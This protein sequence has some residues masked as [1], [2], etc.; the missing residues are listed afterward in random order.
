MKSARLKN[1]VAPLL[2]AGVFF[3]SGSVAQA[4]GNKAII[5]YGWDFLEAT[6]ED[7]FRNRAKFADCGADGVL[8]S[9]DGEKAN[10][11]KYQ[12]RRVMSDFR[13]G[14]ADF[15]RSLPQ[16][17]EITVC[18]GLR[19]SMALMLMTPAKRIRWDDDA[20]WA[21]IS[22]N[23]AMIARMAKQGGMKGVA[24][25]HEDYFKAR[26][27][28]ETPDD[29]DGVWAKARQ[30]GREVFGGL[31]AEFPDAKVLGFWMFSDG[32]RLWRAFLNGMLD[33]IPPE[34]RFID[35][36]ENYG[37]QAMADEGDFRADTWYILRSLRNAAVPENRAKYDRGVSVSFGQ[38]IDAYTSSN[39]ASTYFIGPM[40]GSRVE[41]LEDNLAAA[42]R[43]CD[44]LVWVYGERGTWVDWDDKHHAKL[45]PMPWQKRIPG[46]VRALRVAAGDPSAID[47]DVA[48]G[49]LVNLMANS[50]CTSADGK[51]VPKPFSGWTRLKDPPP[52]GIFSYDPDEGASRKGCLKL[53]GDGCYCAGV[54]GLIPGESVYVRMKIKGM[55]GAGFD[56]Q[57]GKDRLWYTNRGPLF[58]VKNAPD[59]NGWR[60]GFVRLTVPERVNALNLVLGSGGGDGPAWFDD[61]EIFVRARK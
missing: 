36:N 19:E 25:D 49:E 12:G 55:G 26:Q 4:A 51:S 23:V 61:I 34:A 48:S 15:R 40:N 10:G 50:D 35:G 37:Y 5:G 24:I 14:E 54:R 56:W 32:G 59:A 16:L 27:F 45:K 6:T 30:R 3:F 7:V 29:P 1:I 41:R 9:V 47:A 18:K 8:M 2:F 21:T 11:D 20:A 43:Y 53:D 22:N 60:T 31:F 44:D 39:A 38:Y 42:V 46:F 17:K 57:S 28:N 58:P 33:T 52:E 13:M